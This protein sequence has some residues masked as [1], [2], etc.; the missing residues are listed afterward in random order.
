MELTYTEKDGILYPDIEETEPT[1][2]ELREYGRM[3]RRYLEEHEAYLY[4]TM[5][6]EGTLLAHLLET[7]ERAEELEE[8]LIRSMAKA[9]GTTEQMKNTDPLEW[10]GLMNNYRHCAM[11]IVA[12]ELIFR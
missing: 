8:Q 10:A 1:T 5:I 6:V 4:S 11:E 2:G 3:R 9:D 7:Q 12:K